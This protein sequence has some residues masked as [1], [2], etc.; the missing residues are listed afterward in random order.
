MSCQRLTTCLL[1]ISITLCPALMPVGVACQD[2]TKVN[3]QVCCCHA[4]QEVTDSPACPHCR[5]SQQ[6]KTIQ[7]QVC[8]C[9]HQVPPSVLLT[10]TLEF[11][12]FSN[13]GDTSDCVHVATPSPDMLLSPRPSLL[14]AETSRQIM[15]CVWQT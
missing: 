13:G 9:S 8:S 6:K 1:L 5:E 7:P 15:F 14:S 2:N 10:K 3:S 4:L 11:S 12:K